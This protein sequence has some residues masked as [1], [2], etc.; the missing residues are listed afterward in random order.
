MNLSALTDEQL[1]KLQAKIE[2]TKKRRA[3]D[4]AEAHRQQMLTAYGVKIICPTCEGTG[5]SYAKN[6][7]PGD[8]PDD[9]RTC[10]GD[11]YI[12]APKHR[13]W[14]VQEYSQITEAFT[15]WYALEDIR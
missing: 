15:K 12:W 6:W 8:Y 7:E 10:N 1:A 9:C 11:G 5:Q 2:E 14:T 13:A 3:E 4:K